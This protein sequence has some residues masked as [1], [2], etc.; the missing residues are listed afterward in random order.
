M[1]SKAISRLVN[2]WTGAHARQFVPDQH[3]SFQRPGVRGYF[4]FFQA[5]QVL[6][7]PLFFAGRDGCFSTIGKGHVVLFLASLRVW[8]LHPSLRPS[9]TASAHSNDSRLKPKVAQH[10][11]TSSVFISLDSGMPKASK[12]VPITQ[13][14]RRTLPS[15]VPSVHEEFRLLTCRQTSDSFSFHLGPPLLRR[16]GAIPQTRGEILPFPARLPKPDKK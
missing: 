11:W 14:K 5:R 9:K 8:P 6:H 1:R 13:G 3:Q 12:V 4:P 15:A 2:F 7:Q 16:S 10:D